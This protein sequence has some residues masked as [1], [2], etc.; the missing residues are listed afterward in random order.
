[1]KKAFK[2]LLIA[3]LFCMALGIGFST[4]CITGD[5]KA[6]KKGIDTDTLT[7]VLENRHSCRIIDKTSGEQWRFKVFLHRKGK[8]HPVATAGNENIR[9]TGAGRYI[10]INDIAG[11]KR[12]RVKL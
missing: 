9:V 3:F 5:F 8:T 2:C 6:H 7:V 11:G 10:I 1:M 12:Y 4:K